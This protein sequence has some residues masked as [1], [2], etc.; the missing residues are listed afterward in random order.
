MKVILPLTLKYI[1]L[2]LILHT[3]IVSAKQP[4]LLYQELNH[5][6][7]KRSY[8]LHLPPQSKSKNRLPVM[9]VLHGGGK[10]DGDETAKHTGYNKL[11][12]QNNFIV[13][14]P[15]GIGSQW[16]DGRGETYRNAN[17]SKVDD[18]GFISA[19]INK[20][21]HTH[22]GDARRVYVT[23]ISN[24]GMMTLRLGCELS[25]KLAAIAPI[26]A[27]I[28]QNIISR[29]KPKSTLPVLLMNG[30]KDPIVPWNGGNVHFFR[31]NM[32]RVVSTAETI[33]FW[34][35]HNRCHS[36]PNIRA[37]PDRVRRDGST[38]TVTRYRN[39]NKSCDVVLYTIKGGGH[40]FPGSHTRELRLLTGR[41]N[42]D[43]NGPAIVWNF[44]KRHSK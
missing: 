22:N 30:T 43:I 3:Q 17:N 26:I 11:A 28:P 44:F 15:N 38:V 40:A 32:G 39:M 21:I 41:K 23:G 36:K 18:V 2:L 42:K 33:D 14:Y 37:V 9:L 4:Q 29:C 13:A 24:G 7:Q 1:V 8:Y 12:D 10:A 5:N 31:K 25:T 16:N 19:L 35:K 20:L 6:A 34:V 27:N